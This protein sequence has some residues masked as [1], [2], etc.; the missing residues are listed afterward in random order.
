MTTA[1]Y[2]LLKKYRAAMAAHTA[3]LRDGLGR[4]RPPQMGLYNAA[5]AAKAA[6]KAAK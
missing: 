4:P 5:L 3:A 6:Y 2:T 1:K